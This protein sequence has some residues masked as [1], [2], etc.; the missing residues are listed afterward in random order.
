MLDLADLRG[1]EVSDFYACI[2]AAA[3]AVE[4][5]TRTLNKADSHAVIGRGVRAATIRQLLG[6]LALRM[7]SALPKFVE[8]IH[9]AIE[10]LRN[11]DEQDPSAKRQTVIDFSAEFEAR[12]AGQ[13]KGAA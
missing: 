12:R 13:R 4:E 7:G 1:K 8:E 9:S 10:Y 3:L 6:P 11:A 2:E 5:T